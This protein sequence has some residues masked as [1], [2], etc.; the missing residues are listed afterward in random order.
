MH[1]PQ[2][3]P[4]ALHDQWVQRLQNM[5]PFNIYTIDEHGTPTPWYEVTGQ[6]VI[7]A[8]IF[9]DA[10]RGISLDIVSSQIAHWGRHVA[11]CSRIWQIEE[12]RFRTWK[13]KVSLQLHEEAAK[14]DGKKATKEYIESTYRTMEDYT[15]HSIAVERA[16]EAY[17]AALAIHQAFRA[18]KDALTRPY[19]GA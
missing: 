10:N 5:E 16:E 9:N 18:K 6:E 15:K 4:L 8:L 17:N 14:P 13:A 3:N 1:A 7:Q 2:N 11:Q 12:R 19:T